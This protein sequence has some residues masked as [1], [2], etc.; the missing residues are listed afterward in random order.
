MQIIIKGLKGFNVYK[1]TESYI[2]KKFQKFE[3][4]VKEPAILELTLAHTHASKQ[5]IDKV[6]HLTFTM[7]G[8]KKSEHLEEI[9]IHFEESVDLLQERFENFLRRSKEKRIESARHPKKYYTAKRLE[10][11]AGEI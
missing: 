4:M 1:E 9:S 11:E 2:L 3:K 10:E 7:P 6:I 8:L 5:T